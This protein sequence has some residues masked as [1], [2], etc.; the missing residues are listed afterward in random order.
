MTH[1]L[2]TLREGPKGGTIAVCECGR[3]ELGGGGDCDE[4]LSSD[5]ARRDQEHHQ[6]QKREEEAD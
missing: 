5:F 6:D 1:E 2:R 4:F 3:H